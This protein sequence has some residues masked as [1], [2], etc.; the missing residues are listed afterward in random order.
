MVDNTMVPTEQF[1]PE[2]LQDPHSVY[3]RLRRECPVQRVVLPAG[4]QAWVVTRYEDVRAALAN[5]G[6]RK[7][8]RRYPDLFARNTMRNRPGFV[9]PAL[10]AHMLNTDPPDHIRLR[11]LVTKAFTLRRI[12]QMRGRIEQI[13]TELL[14]GMDGKGEVDLVE[15]FA[16]PL[17][18]TVICELIGMPAEDL[19]DFRSWCNTLISG[20]EPDEVQQAADDTKAYLLKLIAR[21]RDQAVGDLLGALVHARE[22]G[23]QLTETELVSM[24]FLL[25]VAGHETTVSLIA[26]GVL[27]LLKNPEQFAT[28]RAD[29]SLIPGAIEEFL[30]YEGPLNMA[31]FRY[32]NEP[33]EIGGVLIP[34]DEFVMLALTSANR[35]GDQFPEPDKLDIRRDTAGHLAFGHGMHYCLGAPLARMEA[36]IAFNGLF[37]RFDHIQLA[38]AAE[39]LRWREGV[40]IRS[41]EA[42]P[43]QFG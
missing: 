26:S 15:A 16:F 4:L 43:V 6:L 14:D 38:G 10:V 18:I 35:D 36:E 33:T 25:L 19:D 37:D 2:F 17:P 1:G 39:S 7:D 28:L 42:L 40:V 27:S 22:D 32:T 31:T 3:S 12:E 20:G 8:F 30:R 29:R 11:K 21:K 9:H 13:T 23:D 24:V 5:P 41:L 34:A